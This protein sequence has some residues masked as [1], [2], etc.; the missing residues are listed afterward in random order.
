MSSAGGATGGGARD[1]PAKGL[2]AAGGAAAAAATGAAEAASVGAPGAAAAPLLTCTFRR[3]RV[4]VA[5]AAHVPG[6]TL[7]AAARPPRGKGQGRADGRPPEGR[8][9][10]VNQSQ[11]M[12]Q[13]GK[14]TI[15][16]FAWFVPRR[17]PMQLFSPLGHGASSA[18]HAT[19]R[20]SR[21][22]LCPEAYGV[23][24]LDY[25]QG[26]TV[27]MAKTTGLARRPRWREDLRQRKQGRLH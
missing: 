15:T 6:S 24:R 19:L 23:T 10:P 3:S 11:H 8:R 16:A 4:A 17:S 22:E 5:S 13:S 7:C 12:S 27:S 18:A 14:L 25:Y 2:A 20:P 26:Y 1:I 9:N 21:A